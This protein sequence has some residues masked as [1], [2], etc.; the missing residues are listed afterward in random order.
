M[1][2]DAETFAHTFI[3]SNSY[4]TYN[5]QIAKA[6]GGVEYAV[7]LHDMLDQYFYLSERE[8][9]ISHPD[10]GKN[11]MFYTD[12]VCWDRCAIGK[13][14]LMTATRKL[15]ELGILQIFSFGLPKKNYYRFSFNNLQNWINSNISS[16]GAIRNHWQFPK[17]P[18]EAPK[19]TAYDPNNNPKI[20]SNNKQQDVVV[21]PSE[22][23]KMF[24][25]FS[26]NDEK[27]LEFAKIPIEELRNR[28]LAYEQYRDKRYI[29]NPTGCIIR[30]VEE[31]WKPSE[32]PSQ[33]K[34]QQTEQEQRDKLFKEN[35]KQALELK[36]VY[37]SQ[38]TRQKYFSVLS[39][40]VEVI[41][42]NRCGIIEFLEKDCILT[43]KRFC[44]GHFD[45][46]KN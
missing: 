36:E 38:F 3:R 45:S 5:I 19:G 39:K 37:Q 20:E 2:L 4:R 24:E 11:L 13:K 6:L 41:F 14:T 28:I 7:V 22:I 29:D 8:K 32:K 31:S 34:Q 25:E 10:H 30:A 23:R 44:K 33:E 46:T 21:V 1:T 35:H 16:S 27:L 15:A 26:L 40:G 12:T 17:E 18:L 43:L 9:L 42:D